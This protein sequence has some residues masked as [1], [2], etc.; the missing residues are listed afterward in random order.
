MTQDGAA[1]RAMTFAGAIGVLV[2]RD[3]EDSMQAVLDAPM[4][5]DA[6]GN[7]I[8]VLGR[9][10]ADE[11]ARRESGLPGPHGRGLHAHP[12]LQLGPI[13]ELLLG[14]VGHRVQGRDLRVSWRPW[15][16]PWSRRGSGSS[17]GVPRPRH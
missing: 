12:G 13:P 17:P 4:G 16:P 7:G 10:G 6:L 15:C 1:F 2:E 8:H 5:P 14:Q 3:G 11:V 9:Q